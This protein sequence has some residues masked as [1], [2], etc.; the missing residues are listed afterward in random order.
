M[1]QLIGRLEQILHSE[2][3]TPGPVESFEVLDDLSSVVCVFGAAMTE[4]MPKDI[5]IIAIM[6]FIKIP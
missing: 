6:I 1:S 5:M 4:Q 3:Y 2:F